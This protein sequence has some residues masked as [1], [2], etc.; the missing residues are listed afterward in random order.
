MRSHIADHLAVSPDLDPESLSLPGVKHSPGRDLNVREAARL[1]GKSAYTVRERLKVGALVGY[2]DGRDWRV[3]L[4]AVSDYR[5]HLMSSAPR[6]RMADL[7]S[8]QTANRAS[9]SVGHS[10]SEKPPGAGRV[11]CGKLEE[12][13]LAHMRKIGIKL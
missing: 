10:Y 5:Q 1:L 12:E 11:E 2:K 9:R 4:E 3:P 13:L 6:T 8:G 7:A